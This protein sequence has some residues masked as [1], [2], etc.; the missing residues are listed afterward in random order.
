MESRQVIRFT[1]DIEISPDWNNSSYV[2]R[3]NRK[4]AVLDRI[5]SALSVAVSKEL[6]SVIQVNGLHLCG[7]RISDP[8]L[9]GSDVLAAEVE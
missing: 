6:V 9:V 3:A 4:R 5:H 2:G 1:V 7:T 8:E